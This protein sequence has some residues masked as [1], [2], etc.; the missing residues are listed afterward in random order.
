MR[1]VRIA[2]ETL[3]V[4]YEIGDR[5]VMLTEVAIRAGHGDPAVGTIVGLADEEPATV[6][7]VNIGEARAKRLCVLPDCELHTWHGYY[8]SADAVRPMSAV[9]QL[10][11]LVR[12]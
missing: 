12:D 2:G 6:V 1:T 9:E 8:V 7:G 3:E 11:D 4:P 5:V 10:A